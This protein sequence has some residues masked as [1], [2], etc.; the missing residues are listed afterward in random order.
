MGV[1]TKK[2]PAHCSNE[3]SANNNMR[4][5]FDKDT[6]SSLPRQQKRV[7]NYLLASKR[8]RSV[9]D[10]SRALGQSDPRGHIRNLRLRGYPIADLW[11][12][13]KERERFKRYFIRKEV[14]DGK[15]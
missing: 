2:A 13:T 3:A 8:P 4:Q 9:A 11:D 12:T 6:I 14:I 15:Q 1:A 5:M 10:I 7:L